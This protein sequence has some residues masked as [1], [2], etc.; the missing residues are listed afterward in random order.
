MKPIT[1]NAIITA[2]QRGIDH[3]KN[4][5][6]KEVRGLRSDN[7]RLQTER[8]NLVK[9]IDGMSKGQWETIKDIINKVFPETQDFTV[10]EIKNLAIRKEAL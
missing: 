9:Q 4:I 7:E 8:D 1:L 3:Q 2:Y 5:E 6:H 10:E